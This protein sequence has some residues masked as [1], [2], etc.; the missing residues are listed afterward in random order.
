ML[1][2]APDSFKGTYSAREV[3]E[4]IARGAGP[5]V[6]LCPVADGGEGTLEALLARGGWTTEA[7][8]HDALGRAIV[9]P[10]GWLDDG[11]TAVVEVAAASGLGLIAAHE[12]DAEAAST[13]G[14]GELIAA[15]IS[16]GARRVIV[17]VGGSATTDGGIGAISAIDAAGGPRTAQLIVLA[18]VTTP[19]EHAA[20]I[21]GPQKGADTATVHR[22]TERLHHQ[23]A[24][25]PR[26][27]RGVPHTGA[28][29][30]LSGALSAAYDATLTPGAAWVGPR[31]RR[32]QHAR[33]TRGRGGNRRG[34]ARSPD[35]ARQAHRRDRRALWAPRQA[36]A[37]GRRLNV[38]L[39]GRGDGARARVGA[40]GERHSGP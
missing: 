17:T 14:T 26:D 30:G 9:A 27:P 34:A 20:Q 15:T 37:R 23:A 3:A 2:I 31:R 39:R 12:R 36:A 28:A 40:S 24:T 18:D 6:D 7:A 21:Y 10:I 5:D 1:L 13:Y 32:L 4:A 25:L 35:P 33:H 8:A 22:L 29:G 11:S 38:A 19:Y 16:Q